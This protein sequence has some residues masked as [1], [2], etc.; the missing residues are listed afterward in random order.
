MSAKQT[1]ICPGR[2]LFIR[3]ISSSTHS[4][5]QTCPQFS[6][7][8]ARQDEFNVITHFYSLQNFDVFLNYSIWKFS[9][10]RCSQLTF[11]IMR[12]PVQRVLISCLRR[13]LKIWFKVRVR[14]QWWPATTR[15][16]LCSTAFRYVVSFSEFQTN[17]FRNPLRWLYFIISVWVCKFWIADMHDSIET[18]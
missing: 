11:M 5:A 6:N 10:F 7:H 18:I 9:E 3:H 8:H 12:E 14:P 1:I 13:L 16:A 17:K 2:E 4:K 15:R